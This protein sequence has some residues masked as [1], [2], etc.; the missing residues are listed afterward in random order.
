MFKRFAALT[1]AFFGVALFVGP[2]ADAAP[3]A[4]PHNHA[5]DCRAFTASYQPLCRR[6]Q[7]QHPYGATMDG[8]REGAW[9]EP[10]GYAIVHKITHSGWTAAEMQRLLKAEASDYETWVTGV[11][12]N[13]DW[14]TSTCGNTDGMIVLQFVDADGRP[15]G[16]KLTWRHVVCA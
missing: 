5:T 6:V 12:S 14:I 2:S 3:I 7:L 1:A 9:T 4:A 15:G 16:T 10:N 13:M 8:Q 11:R